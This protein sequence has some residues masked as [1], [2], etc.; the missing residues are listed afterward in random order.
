[1]E[2]IKVQN[3]FNGKKGL[4]IHGKN[5][6]KNIYKQHTVKVVREYWKNNS[7]SPLIFNEEGE[8]PSN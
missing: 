1:M 7:S 6:P 8:L 4:L 2:L 5:K 3:A